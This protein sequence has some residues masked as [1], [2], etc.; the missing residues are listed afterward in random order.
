VVTPKVEEKKPIVPA[1]PSQQIIPPKLPD[2]PKPKLSTTSKK[3]K[4]KII[5]KVKP[6][7]PEAGQ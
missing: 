5:V 6:L 7:L 3:K 2:R 1:L 4:T